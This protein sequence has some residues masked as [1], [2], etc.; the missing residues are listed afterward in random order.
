MT[1]PATGQDHPS[2]CLDNEG[3]I[4]S[5][6][7]GMFRRGLPLAAVCSG[8][9]LA[10]VAISSARHALLHS[11]A[12]DLG[13]F[14]QAVFL[15]SRGLTPFSSFMGMHI[16]G[17][18]AAWLLYPLA[19]LYWIWPSAH[20]LLAIQAAAL[21]LG[22]WPVALLGKEHGLDERTCTLLAAGYLVHPVI[23][24]V[25]LFDFHPE[26]LAGAARRNRLGWFLCCAGL[27]LGCKE[28]V[29]LSVVAMGAWLG[30]FERRWKVG[31]LAVALGGGWFIAATLW[32][33]PA[34]S[35][36]GPA[37]MARYAYL[38]ATAG[39]ALK[40][41]LTHPQLIL[42]R[43]MSLE[44]AEYL[45]VLLAATPA[46][47]FG[48]RFAPLLGAAP[49][50]LLNV[51][52]DYAKQRDLSYQYA[53]LIVPFLVVAGIDNVARLSLPWRKAALALTALAFLAFA[54]YQRLWRTYPEELP[55]LRSAYA[56]M[57]LVPRGDRL[58]TSAELAPH[59]AHRP[60]VLMTDAT[61]GLPDLGALDSVLL[62]RSRPG[63][64]SDRHLVDSLA[65][66]LKLDSAFEERY[67]DRHILLFVRKRMPD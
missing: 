5:L 38:G 44:T 39:E 37:A 26:A 4:A 32:I 13:I 40:N 42:G 56:A 62:S 28:L 25:N 14:D 43:V 9:F 66:R 16:L 33:I 45:G 23:F 53:A 24:N 20:W 22:A 50:I 34:C 54:D 67:S 1:S 55:Y 6:Y 30:L 57:A 63:W 11:S 65:T 2:D 18:H 41:A 49:V 52:A 59:L 12:Y 29:G 7:P 47:L 35:G 48:R 10:F 60:V 58:L 61:R 31:L 36:A 51:L 46:I 15:I 19:S 8:G 3:A 17:D 21:A 64:R 27:A